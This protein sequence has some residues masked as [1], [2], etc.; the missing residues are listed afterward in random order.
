MSTAVPG[1]RNITF[2][3]ADSLGRQAV[4]NR[5]L[6][7]QQRCVAGERRCADQVRSGRVCRC[8]D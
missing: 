4:A 8:V 2:S 6:V 1:V 5:T 3:V 7:V